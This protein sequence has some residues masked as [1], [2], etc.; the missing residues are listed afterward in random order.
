MKRK[1]LEDLELEKEVIDKIMA[2][3]GNDINVAKADYE[4]M[5]QKKSM[6]RK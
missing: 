2:E 4:T 1:F 3:N 5:K 6:N